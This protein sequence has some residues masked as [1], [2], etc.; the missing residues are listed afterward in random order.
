MKRVLLV[1]WFLAVTGCSSMLKQD[2]PPARIWSLP[3]T[4]QVQANMPAL[5]VNLIVDH[6]VT[7]PGLDTGNILI[8]KPNHSLDHYAGA[9]WPAPTQDLLRKA[10]LEYFQQTEY[11]SAAT[12][13]DMGSIRNILVKSYLWSFTAI[14]S[15]PKMKSPPE[16]RVRM[17]TYLLNWPQRTELARITAEYE[18]TALENRME[19]IVAAFGQAAT[20]AIGHTNQR[21]YTVLSGP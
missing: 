5:P 13:S 20:S 2:T 18:V 9:R 21:I 4:V 14:Y 19:S 7:A 11:Y 1:S 6:V 10:L 12:F 15:D 17:V 3:V 8:R 16:V